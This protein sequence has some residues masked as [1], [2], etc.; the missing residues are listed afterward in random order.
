VSS[1]RNPGVVPLPDPPLL[2]ITDRGQARAP[3]TEIAEALFQAGVRWLMLR[4]KD[5]DAVAHRDLL[6]D[7]VARGARFGATV[8]VNGDL[9][10]AQAAGAAG[11]HLPAGGDLGDRLAEARRA[12]G[13]GALLGASAH[14]FEEAAAAAAAGAGYVTLSPIFESASKPGYGPALGPAGLKGMVARL[15]RIKIDPVYIDGVEQIHAVDRI[16]AGDPNQP[17]S[18]LAVPVIALGGVGAGN[19]GACLA[20][21]AAGVA[22]MGAVMAA[23]DPGAAACALLAALAEGNAAAGVA[24]GQIPR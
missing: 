16:A 11:V 24:S 5:L 8:T 14:C 13:P 7:L 20:A 10:A 22:V 1:A 15:D 21:G 2:V 23:A 19:L 3:L 12:L 4:E 6:C 18:A 17:R 9:A